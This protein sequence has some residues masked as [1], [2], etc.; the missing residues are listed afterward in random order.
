MQDLEQGILEIYP[1]N[2]RP[3]GFLAMI[4]MRNISL[5]SLSLSLF[6]VG[7]NFYYVRSY[8]TLL[9]E[10][11]AFYSAFPLHIFFFFFIRLDLDPCS[12]RVE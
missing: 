5:I 11:S 12:T 4:C 1:R 2:L 3:L 8:Q 7:L 9:G 10:I 6:V